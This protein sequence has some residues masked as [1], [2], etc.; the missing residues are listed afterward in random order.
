LHGPPPDTGRVFEVIWH[1]QTVIEYVIA[2]LNRDIVREI[3]M[4]DDCIQRAGSVAQP[5]SD[6]QRLIVRYAASAMSNATALAAEV[7]SL[8]GVPCAYKPRPRG[9]ARA[10][11]SIEEY[12]VQ[13]QALLAHYQERLAMAERLGLLRLREVLVDIVT[14]KR[15]HV[16]DAA[17]VAAVGSRPRQLN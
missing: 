15:S 8:G 4:A 1:Y 5:Y 12:L 7:L 16:K 13:A 11:A 6:F 9:G 14:S 3:R 2:A 17:I 10:T